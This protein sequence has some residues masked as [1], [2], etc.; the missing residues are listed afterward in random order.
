MTENGYNGWTNWETWI[1]NL[2]MDNDQE[3]YDQYGSIAHAEASKN[4]RSAT[5]RLSKALQEQFDEWIPEIKGPYK[6]LLDGAIREINWHEIAR[7]MLDQWKEK[8]D[9]TKQVN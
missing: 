3:L 7:H 6:D 1:I 5:Y 2:W 4:E 8:E 9:Y